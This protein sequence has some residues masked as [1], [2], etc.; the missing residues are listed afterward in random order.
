[1]IW[2]H[3]LIMLTFFLERVARERNPTGTNY[4]VGSTIW[5]DLRLEPNEGHLP[6]SWAFLITIDPIQVSDLSC[7]LY[8]FTAGLMKCLCYICKKCNIYCITLLVIY[9]DFCLTFSSSHHIYYVFFIFILFFSLSLKIML[10][11]SM[12]LLLMILLIHILI[13]K[14]LNKSNNSYKKE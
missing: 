13:G 11:N 9:S 12:Y 10:M 3:V 6:R 5:V 1:M 4:N 14:Y 8:A 7:L 2:T